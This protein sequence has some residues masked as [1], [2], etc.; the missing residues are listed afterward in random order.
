MKIDYGTPTKAP[1]PNTSGYPQTDTKTSGVV[2]RGNG[3]ATKGK[4]ARG[5]LA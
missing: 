1:T 4:T 5:P 3:K 2:T